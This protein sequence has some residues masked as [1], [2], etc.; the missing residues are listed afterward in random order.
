M[1]SHRPP[2]TDFNPRS[3]E[4]SDFAV[5]S[6]TLLLIDFNPRS[7]EG[8]DAAYAAAT[9]G[10]QISIR[11]PARGATV[12]L[13]I[14]W[15]F[16]KNFNPRSRE[17]SDRNTCQFPFICKLFQ[18]ALPR[19]ERRCKNHTDNNTIHISIRAPAR[20][21]TVSDVPPVSIIVI[22][23]RAPARG[24]THLSTS[25]FSLSL[26]QSALPRG[27]RQ[28]RTCQRHPSVYFN[29]RSREGSDIN[30]RQKVLFSLSKNCVIHLFFITNF[31]N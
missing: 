2:L 17:G 3:R 26:F 7:R 9:G 4:G 6:F 16:H 10:L 12:Q 27:E 13:L 24:A 19:G 23:I 20:G 1:P 11:A 5:S 29:P 15:H 18:S 30:F 8:S 25:S 22:S 28:Y 21:A 14:R 31:L